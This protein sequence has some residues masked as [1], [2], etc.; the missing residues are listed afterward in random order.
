MPDPT[1]TRPGAPGAGEAS[2]VGIID[3]MRATLLLRQR[4]PFAENSFAELVLWQLASPLPGS[5]H[6]FKYRLALVQQ[7]VCVLRYDNESGKGDHRHLRGKESKYLFISPE[8]LI[9]DCLRDA[10][11]IQHEDSGS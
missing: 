10:R 2:L 4:L 8:Q 11:R 3:N 5:M 6:S 9:Q 7:E 1:T